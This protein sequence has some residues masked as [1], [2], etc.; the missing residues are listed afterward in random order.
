MV[1][2]L[3]SYH[4][5]LVPHA[6]ACVGRYCI[7]IIHTHSIT[8]GIQVHDT[9]RYLTGDHSAADFERGTQQGGL[10]PCGGCGIHADMIDDQ[11]HALRLPTRSLS[12]LQLLATA[13]HFGI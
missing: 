12:E 1:P 2:F 6:I 9:L 5:W 13:G 3:R 8:I 7:I 4:K 11:L 10:Y